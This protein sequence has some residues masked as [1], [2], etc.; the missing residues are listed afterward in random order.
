M[1][2]L[3]YKTSE[4]GSRPD[5]KKVEAAEKM[6]PPKTIKEIRHVLGLAGFSRRQVPGFAK[7]AAPLANLTNKETP[8]HWDE[9][10]QLT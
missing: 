5:P 3:G 1:T 9:A 6:K 4:E 2:L 7:I 8:Y 10:C